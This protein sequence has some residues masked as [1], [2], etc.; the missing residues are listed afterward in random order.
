MKLSDEIEAARPWGL[1]VVNAI[2][3]LV[4]CLGTI[5]FAGGDQE[6]LRIAVVGLTG[7]L[8]CLLCSVVGSRRE[9]RAAAARA[10]ALEEQAAAATSGK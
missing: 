8:L 5:V 1:W 9:I 2:G 7:A 10:R 3:L 4:L 6:S